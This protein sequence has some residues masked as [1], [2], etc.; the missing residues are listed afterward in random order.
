MVL[1]AAAA[2]ATSLAPPP[3]PPPRP[4]GAVVQATATIRV[5]SGVAL[6]LDA[7]SNPGAPRSR[8]S[9]IRASDGSLTPAKLIEFE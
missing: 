6:K 9:L 2:L 4:T 5:I 8:N 7:P 1:F 3:P